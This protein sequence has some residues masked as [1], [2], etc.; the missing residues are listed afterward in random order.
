MSKSNWFCISLKNSCHFFIHAEVRPKPIVNTFSRALRQLHVLTSSF[1]WFTGLS[2]SFVIGQS[3][4][5]QMK[6]ALSINTKSNSSKFQFK[7]DRG[8]AWKP[9]ADLVL[10]LNIVTYFKLSHL[11]TSFPTVPL[12]RQSGYQFASTLQLQFGDF[13]FLSQFFFLR[14][15]LIV[16][17]LQLFHSIS[18]LRN[19]CNISNT[20]DRV[21]PHFQTPRSTTRSWVYLKNFVVFGNV[22][23]YS[24]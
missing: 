14:R 4:Y 23:K 9:A 5:T 1:D 11:D 22:V 17:S 18:D 20:K 10:F 3:D 7:Q 13:S 16:L 24:V 6:A 2:T 8:P 21:W 12:S 19:T 15:L